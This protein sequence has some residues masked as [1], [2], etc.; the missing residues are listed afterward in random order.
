MDWVVRGSFL[1]RLEH[2]PHGRTGQEWRPVVRPETAVQ[3]SPWAD[4]I[5][6]FC[7][8]YVAQVQAGLGLCPQH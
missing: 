2:E 5:S 3:D 8:E 6:G 1:K 4:F 7:I